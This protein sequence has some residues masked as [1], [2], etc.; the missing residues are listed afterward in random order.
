MKMKK[1]IAKLALFLGIIFAIDLALSRL[2]DLGRPAD[3]AAF[4]DSKGVYD[5][6]EKVDILFVGDSQT[7]DGF[8][9]AVFRE[10]LGATAFNY[11]VYQLS[12]FEGY[13]LLKDLLSRRDQPP[14]LV[15]LGTDVQ[16]FHYRISDG[17]YSPLFIKSP[18][19][20]VPLLF[21]S[22]NLGAITAAGRKK[23]LFAGMIK[24][25]LTGQVGADVRREVRRI[26]NGYLLNEKHYADFSQFD[27]EKDRGFFSPVP[28]DEQKAYFLKTIAYL[29]QRNIPFVIANLPM[30]RRFLEGMK[31]K[32]AYQQFS[33]V[34]AEI[35]TKH[36][37]KIFN[38]NHEVLVNDLEDEEFLDGDH[39]CYPGAKK[40]SAKFADYLA[41]A[42][43][44]FNNVPG[45]SQLGVVQNSKMFVQK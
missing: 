10:K 19:N 9:P 40:F 3:Y 30:H 34:M 43:F 23:Y 18:F 21:K 15:V 8:V 4:V 16:M 13:F 36:G 35:E 28:V 38:E 37:V 25:V 29:Q 14:K 27:C 39:L 2:L 32:P 45:D 33:A 6:L 20:L 17:R 11:G 7:A 5:N 22:D 44:D 41:E 1:F 12:P 24:W 31:A 26:E 42:G